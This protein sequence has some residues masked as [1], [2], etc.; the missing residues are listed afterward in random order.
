MSTI[1][2]NTSSPQIINTNII[3]N[4]NNYTKIFMFALFIIGFILTY[5]SWD[6]D[7]KIQN[8]DC[9]S[10]SLKTSNKI[11]LCIG[12]ILI[13][14]TLSFY[15][16]S[17]SCDKTIIGFRYTYYISIMLLLGI[18]LIILGAIISTESAKENCENAGN[19]SFI[20][21]LGIIILLSCSFYFFNKYKNKL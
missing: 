11:V 3:T 4:M 10:S 7:S 12:I 2:M 15:A 6:I 9:K 16:C 18:A 14:S 21:G 19:P 8:L 17:E 1:T 20:W 13:T 5:V